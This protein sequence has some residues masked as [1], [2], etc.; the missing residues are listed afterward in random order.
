MYDTVNSAFSDALKREG[1]VIY[2]Y[3]DNTP[4]NV[5]FRRNSDTNAL[6]NK[7]TIY[8]PADIGI[9]AGQLLKFKNN[10]YLAVNSETSENDVYHKSDL[11]QTNTTLESFKDGIESNTPM[12][13][14]DVSTTIQGSSKTVLE[15]GGNL[16]MI[17]IDNAASRALTINTVFSAMGENWKI[18]NLLYKN[19]IAYIYVEQ[20]S[21]AAP[22]HT[23]SISGASDSY[24]VGD[25]A[26]LTTIAKRNTD[27][28]TNATISWT[29]SDTNLAT[30][31]NNGN[32]SFLAEGSVTI[33]ALWVEHNITSTKSITINA[34]Q[35]T[36][37]YKWY[38]SDDGGT[39]NYITTTESSIVLDQL[40]ES[41]YRIIGIEKWFGTTIS[42]TNDTYTFHLDAGSAPSS[43]YAAVVV[44]TYEYKITNNA[45][46]TESYMTVTATSSS[47][48]LLPFTVQ[49]MLG[50]AF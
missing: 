22:T 40:L 34:V 39:K 21:D 36:P 18:I 12:Y 3:S 48:G 47:S 44:N 24:Y 11:F 4:Y 8:Y 1:K 7:S 5:I 2:A 42:D 41:S 20:T 37:T 49:F 15:I 6:Q 23:L 45:M 32:V 50:G 19:N 17:T 16:E 26:T 30:I 13:S 38:W 46:F 28:V 35:V 27:T 14:Y 31:D 29:S 10:V 43:N 33:T 25:T 9:S